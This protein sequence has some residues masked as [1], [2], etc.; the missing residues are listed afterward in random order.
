MS[1]HGRSGVV[2]PP[3]RVLTGPDAI[4][5]DALLPRMLLHDEAIEN[6]LRVMADWCTRAEAELAP[7]AKTH[8]DRGLLE[9]QRAHGAWGFT[10]AT[11]RQVLQLGEWGVPRILH[12]NL[13]VDADAAT[14]IAE[15][16]L[17]GTEI[18]YWTYAD[19]LESVALLETMFAGLDPHGNLPRIL[20]ESGF[21]GGRS[22][23]RTLDVAIETMRAVVAS[24]VLSLAGASAFEGLMPAGLAEGGIFPE[25][26]AELLGRVAHCV[27]CALAEGWFEDTPI[28][29]AGG[30]SYPDL[31]VEHLG[32]NAL[33]GAQLVLRS[34]C[35]LTHDHGVYQ[36]TSPFG[37]DRGTGALVSAFELQ[38]SVLSAPEPGLAI[39]GFGR[40]EV[41]TDDRLPIPLAIEGEPIGE[42]FGEITAVN[43]HHAFLRIDDG[44]VLRPGQ[45]LSFGISHPCGAFDRWRRIP[46]VD[47]A[48]SMVGVVEPTL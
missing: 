39:L 9:R 37:A 45:M 34:G 12:A 26:A 15:R 8:M 33:P 47:G 3:S 16:V 13:L 46:L 10:A 4:V 14:L 29:S 30:S 17:R 23:A 27:G 28:V 48:G 2:A 1:T 43:D 11:P 40:R 21:V 24:P 22:G 41:P 18:E 5:E 38:A 20:V 6:N 7:H 35:Y 31:V 36:R 44:T 19:S 32:H 25:G 42:G